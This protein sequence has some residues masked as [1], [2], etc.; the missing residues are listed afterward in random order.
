MSIARSAVEF[1]AAGLGSVVSATGRTAPP[2][3][4][5]DAQF[6]ALAVVRFMT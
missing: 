4:R 5:A 3:A 6:F 2:E 1:A